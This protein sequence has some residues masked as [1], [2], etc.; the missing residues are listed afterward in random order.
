MEVLLVED[1]RADALLLLELLKERS[2]QIHLH[3]VTDGLQ[4][5]DFLHRRGAFADAPAPKL[6]MLDLGLPML[7]GHEV[8]AELRC[9]HVARGVPIMVLSTSDSALDR[10]Q[11]LARGAF[12][13][14]SKPRDLEGYEQLVE[15]L[16]EDEFPRALKL[17]AAAAAAAQP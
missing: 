6:V 5:L 17:H 3:W 10:E 15:R 11:C 1:N 8:L 4:A 16:V 13:Y 2:E 14:I 7:S 12:A 9:S